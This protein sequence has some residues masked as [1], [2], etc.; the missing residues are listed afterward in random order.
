MRHIARW[1]GTA[2]SALVREQAAVFAL[3]VYDNA[4]YAGGSFSWPAGEC[5]PHR[6]VGRNGVVGAGRGT[7]H[8][9]RALAVYDDALHVG[10]EFWSAGGIPASRIARW[11][12]TAWSEVGPG[13]GGTVYALV[14]NNGALY[15]GGYF[16]N[17]GGR[18]SNST[19]RWGRRF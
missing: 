16:S 10:G 12:G 6:A 14:V 13:I 7:N 4:L 5:E 1:D 8:N 15:A 11:N 17:A 9:V 3:A 18:P 2:W 19:A